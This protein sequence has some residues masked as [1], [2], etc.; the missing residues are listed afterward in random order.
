MNKSVTIGT[1]TPST[2]KPAN[3]KALAAT[4]EVKDFDLV[5]VMMNH[6]EARFNKILYQSNV[7][8][9]EGTNSG[10]VTTVEHDGAEVTLESD[11][12]LTAVGR[13]PNTEDIGLENTAITLNDQG[14]IVLL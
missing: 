5:K 4:G 9:I 10:F 2:P 1:T 13:V 11:R 8:K 14:F 12:V 7:V 3:S 6:A